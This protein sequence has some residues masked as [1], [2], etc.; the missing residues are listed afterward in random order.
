MVVIGVGAGIA[1]YKVAHVVRGLRRM[2]CRTHVIPTERSL[3][4]VGLQTWQELSENPVGTAVFHDS[5]T[6]GHIEL[7][8]RADLIIVAPCT[9]DLGAKFRTGLADDL[10]TATFLASRAPKLL[11]PAMHTG[12]WRN[13]ATEENFRVL[14]ERGVAIL[15]PAEGS[16]S[17]GDTGEGR[18]PEP[19]AILEAAA[20]I[21]R[22]V[23]SSAGLLTGKHVMVSAGG[24]VEMIDP[25]RYMSNFSTGRQG[26]ELAKA[27]ASMGAT[28]TLLAA[29]CEVEMP[30]H[31][32]IEVV[33]TPS[34][35]CMA[36]EVR[37]RL[38]ATDVLIMAA[39]VADYRPDRVAEGKLK[40]DV[41]GDS[42]TLRLIPNPD[43]LRD[44]C[45]SPDR[46]PIVVG[47]AAE[48]G[49]TDEVLARGREKAVRKGADFLAINR[50]GDGRG[51]GEVDN[52]LFVVDASGSE[53]ARVQ[54]SKSSLARDL[55][56]VI[57]G[58][59]R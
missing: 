44:A 10:L 54:G 14:A 12:M 27:A 48:T 15:P 51:F 41:W 57:V 56:T 1:A 43:I 8:R 13:A 2:G 18:M 30:R 39:A 38:A 58:G 59:S 31:P 19:D 24:T 37:R 36:D 3:Q 46:P 4:F 42:P 49:D 55:L 40:K 45:Q 34:A 50:V 9:A 6:A 25:V 32:N 20:E 26:V 33:H 47:F 11:V 23:V 35:S 28:V 52:E 16:L 29:K 17:S 21:L 7:A 5:G 53:V 22:G